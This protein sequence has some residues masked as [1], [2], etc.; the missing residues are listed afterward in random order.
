MGKFEYEV[1]IESQTVNN[2][3]VRVTADDSEEASKKAMEEHDQGRSCCDPIAAERVSDEVK[4]V[5]QIRE[6]NGAP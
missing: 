6:R 5:L 3:V 1:V 4:S 2:Y